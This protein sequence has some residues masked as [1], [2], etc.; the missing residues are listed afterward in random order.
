MSAAKKYS[1]NSLTDLDR[2]PCLIDHLHFPRRYM[3]LLRIMCTIVVH[4]IF[5]INTSASSSEFSMEM[6]WVYILQINLLHTLFRYS[7]DS[8]RLGLKLLIKESPTLSAQIYQKEYPFSQTPKGL[9]LAPSNSILDGS[10]FPYK[11]LEQDVK[12]SVPDW[13]D[14]AKCNDFLDQNIS[15]N[16]SA[17]ST[18]FLT[19]KSVL[20]VTDISRLELHTPFKKKYRSS[21]VSD[22]SSPSVALFNFKLKPSLRPI[23][24]QK[25]ETT[26]SALYLF[27]QNQVI[28][29]SLNT[30]G[31]ALFT[32]PSWKLSLHSL[33]HIDTPPTTLDP[34]S[35]SQWPPAQDK[36]YIPP[37]K[38]NDFS[39]TRYDDAS[40]DLV[41][42]SVRKMKQ[43]P[44]NYCSLVENKLKKQLKSPILAYNYKIQRNFATFRFTT[45]SAKTL[46]AKFHCLLEAAT[47]NWIVP[48]QTNPFGNLIVFVVCSPIIIK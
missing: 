22:R 1:F 32:Q 4:H 34:N 2:A 31:R 47:R 9:P 45:K 24:V 27:Y 23:G 21:T 48:V 40:A 16:L 42:V 44:D 13:T 17:K 30:D 37:F 20:K 39:V 10:D 3:Q 35:F 33:H 5:S 14:P 11:P 43:T 28:T 19:G 12:D 46:N 26:G 36:T 38:I 29:K 6:H 7:T 8:Y 41:R 15:R 18:F 25:K